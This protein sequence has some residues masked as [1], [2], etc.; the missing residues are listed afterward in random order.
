[1]PLSILQKESCRLPL[2]QSN[3]AGVFPGLER[4]A[5]ASSLS[6][7]QDNWALTSELP[8]PKDSLEKTAES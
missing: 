8:E 5:D 4:V 6:A 1:M 3:S 2:L 7:G